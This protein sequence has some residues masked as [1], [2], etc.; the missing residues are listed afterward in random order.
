M[1]NIKIKEPSVIKNV[2]SQED[3]Q[4][5]KDFLKSYPKDTM[6]YSESMG[7]HLLTHSVINEYAEKLI[8]L[9]REIFESNGLLSSYSLFSHYEGKNASLYRHID[10]N[11]CTYTIDLCIYQS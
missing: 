9:A 2:F 8:P 11:A 7:R 4:K 10:D 6:D 3:Y 5:L 1:L